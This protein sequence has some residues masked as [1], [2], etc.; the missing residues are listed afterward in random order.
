MSE[1]VV[2]STTGPNRNNDISS[3]LE[4]DLDVAIENESRAQLS[5]AMDAIESYIKRNNITITDVR[6]R[7][8]DLSQT[9]LGIITDVADRS[10]R[11]R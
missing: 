4:Y 8:C 2:F 6:T 7:G 1:Y 11:R 10:Q 9:T 5:H 3:S